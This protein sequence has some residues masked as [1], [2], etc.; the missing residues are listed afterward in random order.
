MGRVP[1]LAR[2]RAPDPEAQVT[3]R[4]EAAWTAYKLTLEALFSLK[5]TRV[6]T[7]E[8]SEERWKRICMLRGRLRD[9]HDELDASIIDEMGDAERLVFDVQGRERT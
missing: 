1:V 9:A 6:T 5:A 3:P 2:L 4:Q 8:E 7:S